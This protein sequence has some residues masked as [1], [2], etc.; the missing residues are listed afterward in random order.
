M[1]VWWKLRYCLTA[2]AL[3][4]L[5]VAPA[6]ADRIPGYET[7]CGF[8]VV[9]A[10]TPTISQAVLDERGQP[11]I[12]LD[13]SL[14]P[15]DEAPRR[16]FLIMHECAHHRMGHVSA[17]AIS[18]RQ[19]SAGY[20]RDTEMSADCWAAETLARLGV[21]RPIEIMALR[22]HRAGLYSPGGGYPAGIQRASIIRQCAE[23]GR[24][25]RRT[26]VD[27]ARQ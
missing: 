7:L 19:R 14:S 6:R 22:F 4:C 15:P 27:G 2:L 3:S 9:F 18:R 1:K 11:V 26:A 23:T 20:V 25:F 10:P 12:V 24:S 21:D 13:P 5:F 8:N 17:E 16:Q